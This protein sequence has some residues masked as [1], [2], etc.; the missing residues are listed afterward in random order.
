MHYDTA[1][2]ANITIR[3]KKAARLLFFFCMLFYLNLIFYEVR[4]FRI[5]IKPSKH[6]ENY[7]TVTFIFG[8]GDYYFW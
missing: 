8:F 5:K 4:K 3:G 2:Q 1:K 6:S 7:L